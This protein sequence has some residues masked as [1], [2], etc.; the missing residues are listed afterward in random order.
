MPLGVAE[1]VSNWL[2][3]YRRGHKFQPVSPGLDPVA[4]LVSV[5]P[6]G[7]FVGTRHLMTLRIREFDAS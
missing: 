3:W 5:A 4:P 1:R 7:N 2:S 6:P